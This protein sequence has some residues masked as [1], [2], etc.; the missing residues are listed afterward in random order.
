MVKEE[1]QF[2]LG[3]GAGAQ[4]KHVPLY[5][6]LGRVDARKDLTDH[7]QSIRGEVHT[8]VLPTA[9]TRPSVL[10]HT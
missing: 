3:D 2:E 7:N 9:N 1:L 4:K 8:S 10:L 6:H 5:V